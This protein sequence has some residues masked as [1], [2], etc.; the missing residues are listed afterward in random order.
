LPIAAALKQF[1]ASVS[2]RTVKDATQVVGSE[3]TKLIAQVEAGEVA[4]SKARA[5]PC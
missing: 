4:V 1:N 2:E 5:L 3:D